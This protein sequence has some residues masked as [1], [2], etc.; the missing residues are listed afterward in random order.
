MLDHQDVNT[1][2]FY[3]AVLLGGNEVRA[4][5]KA[6]VLM[7]EYTTVARLFAATYG[8]LRKFLRSSQAE[9]IIAAG[10]LAR[11]LGTQ[12]LRETGALR[13]AQGV[14]EAFAPRLS[15][16]ER[17]V[18]LSVHLDGK[19]RVISENEVSVGSLTSSLVH[20]REVFSAAIRER[21]DAV[22]FV[23]NHPSGDPTPSLDDLEITKR[24]VAVSHLVGIR[25][26]DH[27]VIGAGEYASFHEKGLLDNT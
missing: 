8:E 16:M 3:V 4:W 10:T 6:T 27:I 25:V 17:E 18:F 2:T 23:H 19:N 21:A 15:G 5:A 20:P 11:V 12:R 7:K 1:A 9:R 22:V 24:L 26:L 13:T 14:Y